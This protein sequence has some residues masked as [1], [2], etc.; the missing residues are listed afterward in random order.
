MAKFEM[1]IPADM[2][3][4]FERLNGE[5]KS[6]MGEMTKA[7]AEQVMEEIKANVPESFRD[8]DIMRCLHL[9]KVYETPSDGGINTKVAFWGYFKPKKPVGRAWIESRGTDKMAAELVVN[10]FEHGRS[11]STFPKHPFVRKSFKKKQIIEAMRKK[12]N[13][14]LKANGYP[15]D[16]LD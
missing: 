16:W 9:S 3:K 6:M 2:I 14:W 1:E 8:S 13:E 10:V 4:A 15:D 7:G 11:S 5:T 12:R